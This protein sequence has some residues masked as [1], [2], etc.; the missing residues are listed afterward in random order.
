MIYFAVA[1]HISGLKMHCS[2]CVSQTTK[3]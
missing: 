3:W 1:K 2:K